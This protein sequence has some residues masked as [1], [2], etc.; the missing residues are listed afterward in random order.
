MTVSSGAITHVACNRD[1]WKQPSFD[2]AFQHPGSWGR[3]QRFLLTHALIT[4]NNR[5]KQK[6]QGQQISKRLGFFFTS[7]LKANYNFLSKQ[8][9]RLFMHIWLA[10]FLWFAGVMSSGPSCWSM[11]SDFPSSGFSQS[12]LPLMELL[13]MESRICFFNGLPLPSA[14]T[15]RSLGKWGM[16]TKAFKCPT[17]RS[18][19]EA[20]LSQ[21]S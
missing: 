8:T 9:K 10:H 12:F 20:S 14:D 6:Y 3:L 4:E 15:Q 7:H 18:P 17:R 13:W 5:K 21:V 19:F 16:A 11:V 2:N 1:L